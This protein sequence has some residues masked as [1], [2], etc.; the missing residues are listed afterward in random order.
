MKTEEDLIG[1]VAQRTGLSKE[2][3]HLAVCAGFTAISRRLQTT[4]KCKIF[5]FGRFTMVR[6]KTPLGRRPRKNFSPPKKYS[7]TQIRFATFKSLRRLLETPSSLPTFSWKRPQSWLV[8]EFIPQGLTRTASGVVSD[9][10]LVVSHFLSQ[11]EVVQIADLGTFT[12]TW[13]APRLFTPLHSKKPIPL[14]SH[15]RISFHAHPLFI[16][17][18]TSRPT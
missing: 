9:F 1:V 12:V 13:S 7:V 5:R 18:S 10:F 6:I 8:E 4:R 11:K 17:L 14:P 15:P 3:V 2:D 16:K